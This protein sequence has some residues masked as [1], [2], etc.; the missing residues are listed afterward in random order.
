MHNVTREEVGKL[1]TITMYPACRVLFRVECPGFREVESKLNVESKFN[2]VLDGLNFW[3]AAYVRLG[4]APVPRAP[5]SPT[6]RAASSSS[7]CR[8]AATRS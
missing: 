7:F 3:R 6:R 5:C 2:V 1:V 8:P 4:E